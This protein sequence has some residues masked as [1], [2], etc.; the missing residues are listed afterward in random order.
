MNRY[1]AM[2]IQ[3]SRGCPYNCEF[4]NVT[5]LF[6]N[7]DA[8]RP[9]DL[10]WD[11]GMGADNVMLVYSDT[12]GIRYR[13]SANGGG[14]WTGE[15]TLTA[16][17]QARWI[18]LERDPSNVVHLVVMDQNN[19]LRAWKWT[20]STW[21]VTSTPTLPSTDLETNGASQNVEPFALA[22]W[23]P[24][25]SATTAVEL[26]SFSAVPGDSSVVHQWQTGSELDNLGF[27]LYRGP[28]ADGPWTRITASMIGR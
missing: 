6:G 18:Q 23:P 8:N 17:Y 27:H 1:A 12:T 13:T 15:Q 7:A 4:C 2:S 20:A 26:M 11:L 9:F 3:F 14:L 24:L 25:G 21:T 16:L 22:T 19:D 5:T 28:S 10:A